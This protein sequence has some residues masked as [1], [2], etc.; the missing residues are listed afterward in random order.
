MSSKFT[1][2]EVNSNATKKAFL[3]L[4]V[5]LY[6]DDDL[7]I[8]PLDEDIEKVFD[9]NKNKLFKE[10][11]AIRWILTDATNKTVG[12]IAAF[13]DPKTA[14][15]EEQPTG[16]SGFFD[17][18]HDQE[19][20]NLLFDAAKNWLQSNGMEAMDGPINFG[21]RDYFWGCLSDGFHEPIY[22]M[23]YNYPYYNELFENYGFKNYFNQF[24]Y[25]THIINN[26]IDPVLKRNA[27]SL[28]QNPDFYFKTL[29]MKDLDKYAQDFVTV[30]N[31]AWARFPGVKAMR[32]QQAV[33]LFRKMK[34]II[35][36]R[37][38][39]FGYYRDEPISFFVM[40]PDLYQVTRNFNGKFHILNELRLMYALKVKKVCTRL[41]GLIFGVIPEF[42]GKGVAAG[43]VMHFEQE[44]LKPGFKYEVL[45]MNWIGDFNPSMIKLLEHIG[46]T[47]R[48]THIT[49]RYLFDR[50]KEFKRAK[51]VS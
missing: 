42:Q 38:I 39:I 29:E 23:P 7:W 20:A 1:L 35:D 17:C 2:T 48:K 22:N 43:L 44:S 4:P 13:F 49:Y 45:E 10:G 40:I 41:I 3:L 24:T 15:K 11:K 14:D 37:V 21:T 6:K 50:N 25:Y 47:V 12:R 27:E 5:N 34:P 32:I 46:G 18:I 31:K 36:P 28:V 26:S 9:H 30:F 51:A 19:A 33:K 16:G 8:R